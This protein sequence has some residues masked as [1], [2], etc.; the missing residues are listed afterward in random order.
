MSVPATTWHVT[1]PGA[2]DGDTVRAYLTRE[3]WIG[4]GFAQTVYSARQADDG[5]PL[6]ATVSLRLVTLDTPERGQPGYREASDDVRAWLAAH[7]G[8]LLVDTYESGGFERL[9]ADV[10]PEGQRGETLSQAML[11]LGWEPWVPPSSRR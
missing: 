3:E 5:T 6:P 7:P 2:V 1:H 8:P 11:Q 10:Y 9:L 4:G